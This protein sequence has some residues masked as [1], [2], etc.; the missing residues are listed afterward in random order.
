MNLSGTCF[1]FAIKRGGVSSLGKFSTRVVPLL[2]LLQELNTDDS[3]YRALCGVVSNKEAT[4]A[5]TEEQ[6]RVAKMHVAE[7]ERGGIH[8]TGDDR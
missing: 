8:L 6:R 2:P 7:Y 4:E 1:A 3:L 5:F